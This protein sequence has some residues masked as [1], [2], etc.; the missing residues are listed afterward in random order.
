MSAAFNI[1]SVSF[2]LQPTPVSNKTDEPDGLKTNKSKTASN[3]RKKQ[4]KTN[5]TNQ[6]HFNKRIIEY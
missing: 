4:I 1:F 6:A 5:E 2:I 3:E